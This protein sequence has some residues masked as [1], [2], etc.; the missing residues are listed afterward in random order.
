M[1]KAG[2][3]EASNFFYGQFD[4]VRFSM[5]WFIEFTPAFCI[6]LGIRIFGTIIVFRRSRLLGV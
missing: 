3:N 1:G 6:F 4:S 2:H 5:I